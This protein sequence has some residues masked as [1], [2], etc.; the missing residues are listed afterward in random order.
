M[1]KKDYVLTA[2]IYG[3]P[4]VL[5]PGDVVQLEPEARETAFWRSRTQPVPN[6]AKLTPATPDA[7]AKT[8]KKAPAGTK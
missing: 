1:S 8:D 2:K 5:E 7:S 4:K 6:A 3:G